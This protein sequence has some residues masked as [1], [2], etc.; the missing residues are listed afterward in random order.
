MN[1]GTLLQTAL[2]AFEV[3]KTGNIGVSGSTGTVLH[4]NLLRACDLVERSIAGIRV[5]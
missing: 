3:V 5:T 1:Y 2:V 4:R